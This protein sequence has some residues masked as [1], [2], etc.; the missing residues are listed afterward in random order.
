MDANHPL[1]RLHVRGFLVGMTAVVLAL[2]SGVGGYSLRMLTTATGT[3]VIRVYEPAELATQPRPNPD[4]LDHVS[5]RSA[6]QPHPDP[7]TLDHVTAGPAAQPRPNPD[8]L[9]HGR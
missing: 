7:D 5:A 1:R 2:L 3:S 9:D 4:T 8:T 6:A